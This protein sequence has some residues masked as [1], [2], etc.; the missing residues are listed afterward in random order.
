MIKDKMKKAGAL[1]ITLALLMSVM[2]L[3]Q[4]GAA[5]GVDDERKDCKIEI[6]VQ[7][8]EMK[9]LSGVGE[10]G[11]ELE[12]L[13]ITVNLY[14]VAKISVEGEYFPVEG[15]S[16]DLTQVSD[17]TTADDWA[18]LAEQAKAEIE[19]N[20]M[21]ITATGNTEEGSVTIT[22]LEAGLYLVD[23]QQVLSDAY[24]YDFTP[25]LV[26]LPNN[27]YYTEEDDTWVYEL[28]GDKAIGLK[29]EKTDRYGD[30]IINK[31]LDSYNEMLGGA[32]FVFQ[33][34]GTKT[35]I[36]TDAV[37]VVYSDVVSMS[38]T[39][40]GSDSIKIEHI[41]AGAEIVVT[42]VYSGAS[43]ELTS[44]AS[45]T[46]TIVAEDVVETNFSNTMNEKLNGGTGLVNSFIYN[47]ETG[48]WTHSA[49]V[50]STP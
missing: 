23:A 39:G 36:D 9:E 2:I 48:E 18:K 25:F 3:P 13:P 33:I 37:K 41:P 43:Y 8:C 40:A 6:N 29:P 24:Q 11:E 19:V 35:D 30:L 27:Y 7:G 45:Q 31:E 47:N 22:D 20:E 32:N 28:V 14:K 42:E 12:A 21:E 17:E 15:M 1:L 44:A 38:F 34:E 49:S 5:V 46:V 50:D 4:V 10:E 26:S 16:L